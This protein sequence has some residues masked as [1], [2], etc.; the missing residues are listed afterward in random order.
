MAL[1]TASRPLVR[2]LPRLALLGAVLAGSFLYILNRLQGFDGTGVVAGLADLT[3]WRVM[4]GLLAVGVA[5]AA[6]AGQERAIVAWFGLSL[7]PGQAGCAAAAAAAVSQ[8]VGFGPV[9]GALVRRRLMPEVTLGQSFAISAG[10]TLGF[11]AGLG[12]LTLI[13]FAAVPGMPQQ[14][15]AQGLLAAL[16][17]AMV[18]LTLLRLPRAFGRFQ[19]NLFI[20]GR[21][22]TWLAIDLSALAVALWVVLPPLTALS[23]WTM[24]PVFLIALGV[25]I[26][27]GSPGGIGPFEAT[28]LAWLPQVD[29]A[30]L[31]AGILA[32]RALAYAVPALCGAIWTVARPGMATA[33]TGPRCE[34]TETRHLPAQ[35][36]HRLPSAEAQL[37]R[38]GG[39]TLLT[40]AGG[41]MWLSGKL[42]HTRVVMGHLMAETG[43]EPVAHSVLDAV[44]RLAKAEARMLCLYKVDAR[45][46]VASRSR[47]YVVL[48]VAREAVL[49][50]ASFHLSGGE[51]A[52]LRRKLAHARKA[53][54]MVE[55]CATPPLAEMEEV[56]AV[57][58]GAHGRERGFS[59]GRWER[60]YA[61]NQRVITARSDDGRLIAFVTFQ[62]GQSNWVLDLV[63]FRPGVPDGTIYAMITHAL[64][65]ARWL[66]VREV[67][68]AAVPD[69]S[70]GLS[71]PLAQIVQRLTRGSVGLGQ[72]KSAFAPRW[73]PLYVAAPSRLALVIGGLE[74]AR[75]ILRPAALPRGKKALTVLGKAEGWSVEADAASTERAA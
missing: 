29:E 68:L 61:A 7:P 28:L 16:L 50:P 47:G 24:L 34:V 38:Q 62:A 60:T 43:A 66:E 57:W 71:G 1:R 30:G 39:L 23:F 3:L 21:F 8:T 45:I 48:P 69:A 5:F 64:E 6:V 73:R 52:G 26:A 17:T 15:L 14:S 40:L 20:L 56:A 63:R 46:A 4:V 42:A 18:L 72:F 53:G 22:L 2:L 10:I 11:F 25:G 51:R 44:E 19:P 37:I 75:A 35:A 55:D 65:M 67:S 36:L 12:F 13:V 33:A 31:V 9:V 32:F 54:V 41:R 59:M 27:S 70:F 49:D 58:C 74:L